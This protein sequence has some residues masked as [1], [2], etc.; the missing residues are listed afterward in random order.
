MKRLKVA[1][2][3]GGT[4][5]K[6]DDVRVLTN[7]S[8]GKL[9]ARIANKFIVAGHEVTYLCPKGTVMPSEESYNRFTISDVESLMAAMEM[10][11]PTV[12][13]VIHPMA[14]SDFSFDYEGAIKLS[15]GSL[16]SFVQHINDTIVMTPKVISHF[17]GWNPDAILV[18]FKFTSGLTKDEL[19]VVANKLKDTNNLDMVLANDKE[20]MRKAGSHNGILLMDDWEEKCHGKE[21]IADRIYA[22]VIR[23][24]GKKVK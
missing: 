13:V 16:N 20:A 24:A 3:S 7:I 19:K 4:R 14:V 18:G 8:S 2:T 10:V 12:D 21:E 17:K 1:I 15:S 23:L 9:G 6:I 5:E 22:N 11:V